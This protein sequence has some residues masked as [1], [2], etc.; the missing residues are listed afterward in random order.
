M[1]SLVCFD[2]WSEVSEVKSR[3]RVKPEA[4]ALYNSDLI[5]SAVG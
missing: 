1:K 2:V 5:A 4:Y 3:R